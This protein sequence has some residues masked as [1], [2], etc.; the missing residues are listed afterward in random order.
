[1]RGIP[2]KVVQEL[3]GRATIELRARR[4]KKSPAT[5]EDCW[6]SNGEEYGT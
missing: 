1:M 2:L 3:M 5:P 6:A 4:K